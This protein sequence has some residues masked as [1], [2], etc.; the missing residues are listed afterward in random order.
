MSKKLLFFTALFLL[1]SARAG[2][3]Q[4]PAASIDIVASVN[5]QVIT[6]QDLENEI[7]D[8]RSFLARQGMG[9]ERFDS[10]QAKIEYLKNDLVPKYLMYQEAL[11]RGL[12]RQGDIVG[13]GKDAVSKMVARLLQE[14]TDKLTVSD[15]EV[16]QRY[17]R[18]KAEGKTKRFKNKDKARQELRQELLLEKQESAIVLLVDGLA[19][20]AQ[21]EFF[22]ENVQ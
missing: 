2:L 19:A 17:S 1:L 18:L 13:R 22:E 16:E 10:R 9:R 6:R 20:K 15:D 8:Y 11:R 7:D 12:D 14:E 3:A 5:G 21:V 4:Q